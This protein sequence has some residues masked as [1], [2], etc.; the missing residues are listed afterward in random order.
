MSIESKIRELPSELQDK[1]YHYYFDNIK[2][3]YNYI[4]N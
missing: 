1:I 3:T 2:V 4:Q